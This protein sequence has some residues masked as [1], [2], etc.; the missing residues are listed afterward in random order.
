MAETI[1]TA[2]PSGGDA[3]QAAREVGKGQPGRSARRFLW[4]IAA[5]CLV[6]FIADSYIVTTRGYTV[7]DRAVELF[8]QGFPW[9]PLLYVF[10]GINW[11][12][13]TK[14]LVFGVV[15][16]LVFFAWDRR[17]GWLL[18]V[19]SG[20][21][22]IDNVLK[23][24]FQRQRPSA[25]LVHIV[26]PDTAGYSFPSGHAVFFTWLAILVAAALAPRLHPRLR[27]LLW[28]V[29][30]FVILFACISR[31]YDG[32]HWPTDVIGGFLIGLGWS[33]FVLWLPERWLPTP[34]RTWWQIVGR[35]RRKVT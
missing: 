30:A 13:G 33:A 26:Y 35:R 19:G 27:P 17:A 15:V 21:S 2:T 1:P 8:I 4:P 29:A 31:I 22:L 16:A 14:Q 23:V 6:G 12:G 5:A 9:G 7:F 3:R 25:T 18:L 32:V 11:L 20:A 24:A 28:T 10:S 34:S